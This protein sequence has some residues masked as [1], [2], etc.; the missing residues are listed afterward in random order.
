LS[1]QPSSLLRVLWAILWKSGAFFVLWAI[2]YTPIIVLIAPRIGR[3]T[4]ASPQVSRLYYDGTGV[5][6]ILLAAWLMTR[7][8][9]RRPF[10]TLGFNPRHIVRDA[11]LGAG[12]GF[13]WLAVSLLIMWL[14]GWATPATSG[15]LNATTLAVAGIAMFLNTILQEVLARSYIYQTIQSEANS[16]WAILMT[17]IL[18]ALYH[19]GAL[20]G[21]WL[22]G[23]NI[24]LAGV[25]FA[26]AYDR[27]GNLWLPIAIHFVWNFLLGP[28]L[29]SAVSGQ[30]LAS[31]WHMVTIQGPA[32]FTGG[33]FGLEGGLVVTVVTVVGIA[34][35]SIWLPARSLSALSQSQAIA[36]HSATL[37][38]GG[39]RE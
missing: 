36:S 37:S 3:L 38:P 12:I 25:L 16:S 15:V 34:A 4:G 35:M 27:T 33:A 14:F 13:V 2:L 1:R 5:L 17:S 24:F 7:F 22:P 18:F 10:W 19:L 11:L 28:V 39:T 23:V 21:S 31:T 20:Q 32:L 29:G 6:A 8:A 9:D 30:D 26:V